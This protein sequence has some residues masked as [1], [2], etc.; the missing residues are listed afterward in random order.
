[1]STARSP[2]RS[3][4]HSSIRSGSPHA[5]ESSLVI[6]SH[7][8]PLLT[9]RIAGLGHHF[10][11]TLESTCTLLDLKKEIEKKIDL[12]PEYQRLVAKHKTMDDD[13]MVLGG[14]IYNVD[15]SHAVQ[16]IGIGLQNRAKILLLHSS[17]YT[18]D[19]AGVDALTALSKEI[20]EVDARRVARDIGNEEVHELITQLCCKI[21]GV[22]T[23]GS[24][25][26]RRMRKST[27]RKAE[28]VAKKSDES[29]RGIDP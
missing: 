19:K 3:G 24:E 27:I 29:R 11:L 18:V 2:A 16:S 26:L 22:E 7:P 28:G 17:Q 9:L 10:E 5:S 1:M 13:S 14:T 8:A 4:G 23:N 20:A 6:N 21:D 25:A 12:A 15:Q